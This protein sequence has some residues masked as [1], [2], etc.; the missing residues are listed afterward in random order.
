VASIILPDRWKRQPQGAVEVD[1]NNPLTKDIVFAFNGAHRYD[2]AA[3]QLATNSGGIVTRASPKGLG[4]DISGTQYLD[5]AD[6][7]SYNTTGECSIVWGGV[8]DAVTGAYR[9]PISKA[10]GSG[11]TNTPFEVYV[12]S[13]SGK[14]VCIRS[15]GDYRANNLN[16][17]PLTAGN[18]VVFGIAAPATIQSTPQ[19]WVNLTEQSVTGFGGAIGQATSN[20]RGIRIGRRDDSDTQ[21]D[22][23]VNFAFVFNR[24]ISSDEYFAL[25]TNPWQIF[26]KKKRVFYSFPSFP[27]LSS[28][29]VSNI[30]S[31]GGRLT[32]ST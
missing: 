23:S 10:L 11:S 6:T 28:L 3:K 15:N 26:K 17:T 27:V 4:P 1:W 19:A 25:Y 30:T 20:T 32:A 21:L 12:D 2:A 9:S 7:P 8:F 13:I 31:S 29:S 24:K 16:T 5:F 22:G 14:L 18:F